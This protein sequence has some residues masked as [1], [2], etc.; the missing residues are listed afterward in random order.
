MGPNAVAITPLDICHTDTCVGVRW[1][2]SK[3]NSEFISAGTDGQV[4]CNPKF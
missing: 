3:T 2:N 4:R 1:V